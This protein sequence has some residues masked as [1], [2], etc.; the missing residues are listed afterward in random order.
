[1][2][3]N[4]ILVRDD[5]FGLL[6]TDWAE[7]ICYTIDPHVLSNGTYNL[8]LTYSPRFKRELPLIYNA[9]FNANRGFRIHAGNTLKD[10]QGC[11]LVGDAIDYT[12]TLRDSRKALERLVKLIQCSNINKLLIT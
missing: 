3:K 11:I 5:K 8:E 12:Y 7:L 9:D 2:I 4:L 6:Y 10:S 1:M